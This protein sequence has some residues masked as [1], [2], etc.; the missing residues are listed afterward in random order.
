MEQKMRK[1]GRNISI[2]S[3]EIEIHQIF[4]DRQI[5][6]KNSGWFK[7]GSQLPHSL[8]SGEQRNDH[9]QV[10]CKKYISKSINKIKYMPVNLSIY[11]RYIYIYIYI[12][13]D[14]FIER[15]SG[16]GRQRVYDT[17]VVWQSTMFSMTFACFL[18]F[19]KLIRPNNTSLFPSSINVKSL[20]YIP[21]Y[22]R[23]GGEQP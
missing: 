20:K 18:L 9:L 15:E 23:H 19:E 6:K 7:S 21:M 12:L 10:R 17:F 11:L 16:S 3:K 5:E 13:R 2:T 14:I 1:R 8:C 22:G 4:I